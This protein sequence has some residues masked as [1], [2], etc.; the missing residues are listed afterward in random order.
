MCSSPGDFCD[1]WQGPKLF[2]PETAAMMVRTDRE[3][4]EGIRVENDYG[5]GFC[6]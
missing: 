6:S 5:A 1:V 2:D 4:V 3:D